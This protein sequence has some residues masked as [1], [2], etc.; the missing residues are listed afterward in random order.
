MAAIE[1][2]PERENLNREFI[3]VFNPVT[4]ELIGEIPASS[5][6][7][8]QE[9]VERARYAQKT[10]GAL[11]VKERTRFVQRWLDLLWQRH[12][13]GIEI[14]RRENG[15]SDSSAFLEFLAV[16]NI[17]QYQVHNAERVLKPK[18][19]KPIFPVMQQATLHHKP[20]GVVGVI[21][22]WNY[23]LALPYFDLVAALIAGNT[24]VLKPSEVTPFIAQ[25]AADLFYEIDLP[26][27]VL[28]IV[29]G[30]GRTGAALVDFVDYIQ[31][32]GSSAVGRLIG[33]RAVERLIP[34]SLELGGKDAAIVCADVD[35][36]QVAIGLIQGAF[37]NNGQMCISIERAY[38]EE[39]VYDKV[40][41]ALLKAAPTI[42]VKGGAGF[43][44]AMGSMTKGQELERTKAHIA[45]AVAKGA[46]VIYGGNAL[47]ELGP[48][49]FEPTILTDVDHSMDIMLEE[50]FGPV[51]PLMKVKNVDEAIRLANDSKYGLSGSV[52]TK[53]LKRAEKIALQ[54][55]TGDV[56][57]N[58]AQYV[59]G[60]PGLPMG[61][62]RESGLGR[63]NGPE[64]LLKYTA[65]QS[66]LLDNL[67]IFEE[68]P[69]IATK[70]AVNGMK[71]M[72]WLRRYLPFI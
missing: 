62:Q 50:T 12:A 72:H 25:W 49:F 40:V 35:P 70:L 52:F 54:M 42:I 10:W 30:D 37:E 19:R 27:D 46:K 24:V 3:K 38:I 60:T 44:I 11:T 16:D 15:K 4:Q 31:F 51:L 9:A 43:E 23:P 32:T 68:N 20:I 5:R 6:E 55:N 71:A 66:I 1:H 29:Q 2:S 64:G 48:L 65:A 69:V 8:V 53:D 67:M 39:A 58:R 18:H 34:F 47:P 57:V 36:R 14:L 56:S 41:E 17:A 63:R 26:R 28:Q 33:K 45:D 7:E 21:T 59:S 22:P 61:G 13:E